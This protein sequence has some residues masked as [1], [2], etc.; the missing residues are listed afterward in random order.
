[1]PGNPGRTTQTLANLSALPDA[2][3]DAVEAVLSPVARKPVSH[4]IL[5]T[6]RSRQ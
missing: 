1:M 6:C 5:R 3:I 2:A 4:P